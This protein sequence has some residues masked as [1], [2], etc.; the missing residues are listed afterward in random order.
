MKSFRAEENLKPVSSNSKS[1]G[2]L[3]KALTQRTRFKTENKSQGQR[4]RALRD[5]KA[6][7]SR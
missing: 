6:K 4:K 3:Q 7:K 5:K 1:I 2:R